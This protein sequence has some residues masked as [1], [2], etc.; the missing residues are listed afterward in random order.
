MPINPRNAGG[1]GVGGG[2]TTVETDSTL[3]GTGVSGSPLG[4]ADPTHRTA[5]NG[6]TLN[7]NELTID[8]DGN[9]LSVG[10]AGVKVADSF[11]RDR[12]TW[13]ASTSYVIG[14]IVRDSSGNV[15][16]C[17]TANSDA[18]FTQS[19]W[20]NLTP[21]IPARRTAGNGLDLSGNELSVDVDGNTLS[22]GSAGVKLADTVPR[23]RG[24]WSGSTSYIVGDIVTEADGDVQRCKTANT[25]VTF[26][27]ANWDNLTPNIPNR[28]NAG[29]GLSLS[30]NTL[31]V[32]PD[33]NTIAVS[34]SGI[35]IA[36]SVGRDRG[37]WAASTSYVVGDIVRDSSGD[38][39]RCHTAN[40]D[41]VFADTNWDELTA[42]GGGGTNPRGAGD[43]LA[44]S[45]NNLGVQADGATISVSSGGVKIADS[46]PRDRGDW[47]ASVSYVVGDI[48]E[49]SS[50]NVQRCNTSNS[51]AVFTQSKWDNLSAAGGGGSVD[52]S[53][54][55][56]HVFTFNLSTILPSI[57]DSVATFGAVFRFNQVIENT[58]TDFTVLSNRR[59]VARVTLVLSGDTAF[60]SDA[61]TSLLHNISMGPDVD[62][63]TPLE[64]LTTY[65]SSVDSVAADRWNLIQDIPNRH[66]TTL[67]EY[68]TVQS[69]EEYEAS[70]LTFWLED[71]RISFFDDLEVGD[72][73][74]IGENTATTHTVRYARREG[75]LATLYFTVGYEYEAT[76]AD[77]PIKKDGVS[78]AFFLLSSTGE[79]SS[80]SDVTA[81][82]HFYYVPK[83][84]AAGPLIFEEI[85]RIETDLNRT[86]GDGLDLSGNEFSVQA[87]GTTLTVGSDGVKLSDTVARDRGDWV[88]STS[89]IVGDTVEDASGNVQRCKTSNNDA[90]FTQANWDNLSSGGGSV[91]G[92]GEKWVNHINCPDLADTQVSTVIY[93]NTAEVVETIAASGGTTTVVIDATGFSSGQ[94]LY[95]E[96]E[97]S[98]RSISDV[99]NNTLTT[100]AGFSAS[101]ATGIDVFSFPIS[102]SPV[103]SSPAPTT[104]VF[105]VAD[106]SGFTAG[107]AI[108]VLGTTNVSIVQSVTGNVITLEDPLATAPNA[109]QTIS[110]AAAMSLVSA[111][112]T[113]AAGFLLTDGLHPFTAG[114]FI[115]TSANEVPKEIASV[116]LNSITLA[117]DL[118]NVPSN[119]DTIFDGRTDD[120]LARMLIWDSENV[121]YQHDTD[122]PFTITFDS[123]AP[124]DIDTETKWYEGC[125]FGLSEGWY[126]IG[127]FQTGQRLR[128]AST[129]IPSPSLERVSAGND[130][131]LMNIFSGNH[132]IPGAST[133]FHEFHM[134]YPIQVASTDRF[135]WKT[136]A[137]TRQ[138]LVWEYLSALVIEK[139]PASTS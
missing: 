65:I 73:I 48:V 49:D 138:D 9:T 131:L 16:R 108:I 75:N 54:Y 120:W 106:G 39:W 45:G 95:V 119:G 76:D 4:V 115:R 64:S 97:A 51:D 109:G 72:M 70:V 42:E 36:D 89:Y 99:T 134:S 87:D 60:P 114:D 100:T 20:D 125:T 118:D 88:A 47:Q 107:E 1:G 104:T 74:A 34:G 96:G 19:K 43:G 102:G 55:N 111:S 121:S 11:P 91:A 128:G 5:G 113:T 86:A 103:Q 122:N 14:D 50:G 23:D 31:S 123:S 85:E 135:Y 56:T 68:Q 92:K 38:V 40:D 83:T 81:S 98:T 101:L 129:G 93:P 137:N 63:L 24:A 126:K 10:T 25:D 26:T 78:T 124:S 32:N 117:T 41:A 80:I 105:T 29:N 79:Q 62:N 53:P 27:Q 57:Y 61:T 21:D 37:Q 17:Q 59:D 46:V 22:V 52:L 12:G 94:I 110:A 66:W 44:L 132:D 127:I 84:E 130:S 139:I 90:V 15:Q 67:Q 133:G 69:A 116:E 58:N 112:G 35:K 8:T 28:R 13:S 3:T 71:N 33:G 7:N 77:V 30:S 136:S 6:L 82:T 2:L 18:V